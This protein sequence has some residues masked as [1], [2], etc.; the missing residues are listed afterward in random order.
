MYAVDTDAE[1]NEQVAALP[2]QALPL[3]AELMAMLAVSPWSGEIYNQERPHTAN[4]RTH[5]FG[6]NAEGFI[7]YLILEQERRVSVLRVVWID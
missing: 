4:M 1:V 2:A 6:P 7:I 3:Y 5:P